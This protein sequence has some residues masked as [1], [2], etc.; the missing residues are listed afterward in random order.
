M[1]PEYLGLA[2][3]EPNEI[4]EAFGIEPERSLGEELV[5]GMMGM[6]QMEMQLG[7]FGEGGMDK[8]A[9]SAVEEEGKSE[10]SVTLQ[11]LETGVSSLIGTQEG[12]WRNPASSSLPSGP[13]PIQVALSMAGGNVS[14]I[15]NSNKTQVA[16]H[17]KAGVRPQSA[18]MR[19]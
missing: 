14:S 9:L 15:A 4:L 2:D 17:I 1:N 11:P 12:M 3:A 8:E 10:G 19:R 6:S 5:G 7:L 18:K 13:S 16:K